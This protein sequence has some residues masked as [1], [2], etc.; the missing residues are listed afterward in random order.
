MQQSYP[1]HYPA[2]ACNGDM[3]A[4]SPPQQQV[5][6]YGT[7][8]AAVSQIPA[9]EFRAGASPSQPPYCNSNEQAPVNW[10]QQPPSQSLVSVPQQ[11][12]P[13][14]SYSG[15]APALSASLFP[16]NPVSAFATETTP[17]VAYSQPDSIQGSSDRGHF[18]HPTT[19]QFPNPTAP[20]YPSDPY[21][22][23]ANPP[24]LPAESVSTPG[25]PVHEQQSLSDAAHRAP[26]PVFEGHQ[27]VR[28]GEQSVGDTGVGRETKA[29]A[30]VAP[31][32]EFRG[33]SEQPA[34][35]GVQ[36][37]SFASTGRS[38]SNP[39]ENDR[40]TRPP[41]EG[42]VPASGGEPSVRSSSMMQDAFVP[43]QQG[44][45][46]S[47][48]PG[49]G[50]EAARVSQEQPSGSVGS[51]RPERQAPPLEGMAIQQSSGSTDDLSGQRWSPDASLLAAQGQSQTGA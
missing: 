25:Q 6:Q 29:A 41:S 30:F 9:L 27:R 5:Q 33:H 50:G 4:G 11:Y 22:D 14:A 45:H 17:V 2:P 12:F 49:R 28:K 39:V 7:S 42:A 51:E 43:P 15:A 19:S 44:V 47:H 35:G 10:Y 38:V 46:T 8:P 34:Y 3:Q 13:S 16:G 20:N 26:G 23:A 36:A 32:L 37:Q 18:P 1:H 40:Y 31:P 24:L 21:K 48:H